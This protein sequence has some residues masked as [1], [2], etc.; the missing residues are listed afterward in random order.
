M[1]TCHREGI[2]TPSEGAQWRAQ[3]LA[4]PTPEV[5]IC[6]SH[7]GIGLVGRFGNGSPDDQLQL[8]KVEFSSC[9]LVDLAYGPKTAKV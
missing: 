7:I 8:S 4:I 9:Q 2:P 5:S 3:E 1:I 6:R